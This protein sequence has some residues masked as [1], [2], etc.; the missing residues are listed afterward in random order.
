MSRGQQSAVFGTAGKEQAGYTGNAQS[1]FNA[2]GED[3]TNYADAVGGFNAA[4][5][6]VQGGTVQTA[7]NQQT[8]DTAAGGAQ[9]LSQALQG[10][11]VRGGQNPNAAIAAGEQVAEQNQRQLAGEE[12]GQTVA[13]A[14]A[15]T[16]YQE[17]GLE[18]TA[19]VASL[20]DQLAQ[21]QGQLGQ[22]ALS[23]EEKAAQTPS[24]MDELGNGIIQ[25][26]TSFAGGFG[27]GVGGNV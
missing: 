3:V 21:Q 19:K 9:Q 13:R 11:A 27:K 4:N 17:A 10:S 7:Q 22:G 25:A 12:A 5:P 2:A 15:D 18:G 26:G 1:S 24:F 23:E 6:Y 8:A 16:G 20:Q 14:G